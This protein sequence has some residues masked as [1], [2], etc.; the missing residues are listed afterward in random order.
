MSFHPVRT[1]ARWIALGLVALGIAACGGVLYLAL[2]H[3]VGPRTVLWG[4]AFVVLLAGTLRLAYWSYGLFNMHYALSRDALVIRWAATRQVVPMGAITH[5]VKGRPYQAPL[6]G[7]RVEGYEVGHTT[8]LDDAGEPRPVLVYATVPPESQVLIMTQALSYAISPADPLAFA[9]EFVQR[10]R[11]GARQALEER[12]FPAPWARL[13]LWNDGISVGLLLA[14]GAV[15]AFAFG[16]LAWHYP[17][18]PTR[19]SLRFAYVVQDGV[20]L[21]APGPTGPKSGA[22]R[23]PTVGLLALVANGA[24]AAVVHERGFAVAA[25][26]LLA[27]AAFVEIALGIVMVRAIL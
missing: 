16:F 9:D 2:A 15:L 7:V 4:A 23:L 18:L 14:A 27:C 22:W 11:L 6:T 20:G 13:G 26:M 3:G 8:I 24:L 21:T 12:S 17:D 10:R 19:V 1:Q 5:V 25:R